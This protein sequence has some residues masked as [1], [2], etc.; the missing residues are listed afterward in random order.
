[1]CEHIS[2]DGHCYQCKE[3]MRNVIKGKIDMCERYET[4]VEVSQELFEEYKKVDKIFSDLQEKLMLIFRDEDVNSS[5][6]E[7]DA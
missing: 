5:E 2:T 3:M 7:K 4:G 1:M 6:E